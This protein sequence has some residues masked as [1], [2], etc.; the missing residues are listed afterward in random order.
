MW[1]T[2]ENFRQRNYL[3]YPHE[4]SFIPGVFMVESLAIETWWWKKVREGSREGLDLIGLDLSMLMALTVEGGSVCQG[5]QSCLE[6]GSSPQLTAI[7]KSGPKLSFPYPRPCPEEYSVMDYMECWL[8]K[9]CA[10]W[11][12]GVRIYP[13]G[14]LG[15][16]P[17]DSVSG[18]PGK[19]D[20]EE[21]GRSQA[22]YK[23]AARGRK[24]E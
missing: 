19:A 4:P 5:L 17:G 12:L 21:A 2:L 1:L 16:S 7:K 11:K 18:Y 14:M 13:V 9:G 6:S 10:T 15:L 23:P 22:I 20:S 8:K 24:S 3:V